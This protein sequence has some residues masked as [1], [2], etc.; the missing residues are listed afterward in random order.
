M[1]QW[2]GSSL[3]Q[4]DN[5]LSPSRRQAIIWTTAGLLSIGPLWTIVSE[6][7]IKTQNFSSNQNHYIFIQENALETVWKIA[8]ILSW[9]Q[10][11]EWV[12]VNWIWYQFCMSSTSQSVHSSN[13][14]AVEMCRETA[15]NLINAAAPLEGLGYSGFVN[16]DIM[17]IYD[18]TKSYV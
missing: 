16:F 8:A 15:T 10:C 1:R 7:F 17:D 2:M 3:V 14:K 11:V 9:P 4:T 13:R 12:A 6:I 18:V 5:G